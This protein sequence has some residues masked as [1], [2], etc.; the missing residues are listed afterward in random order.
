[1]HVALIFCGPKFDVQAKQLQHKK[2]TKKA[3]SIIKLERRNDELETQLKY[4][5]SDTKICL[6]KTPS[7]KCYKFKNK[8]VILFKIYKN[9]K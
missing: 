7:I 5:V 4:V 1:M 3:K 2:S 8:F 9:I 6:N